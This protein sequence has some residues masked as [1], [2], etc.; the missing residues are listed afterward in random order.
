MDNSQSG[1]PPFAQQTQHIPPFQHV[2]PP[3]FQPPAD[4]VFGQ[5]PAPR[6]GHGRT[7]L[8]VAIGLAVVLVLGFIAGTIAS[9]GSNALSQNAANQLT[10]PDGA[11]ESGQPPA[12]SSP[13][14]APGG[15]SGSDLRKGAVFIQSN[16]ATGNEVAAFSRAS[17]GKLREVGRYRT[18]GNGS[19]SFED[20][21]H[22]IVLGT[23]F[24]ESSPQQNLDGAQL[25]FVTNAGSNSVSV[26][27]VN[28]D[29]LELVTHQPSGGEKP[30]SL[31]VSNGMLYVLNSGELD[32]RFVLRFPDVML[33]NCAHGDQPSV[34]GFRISQE[35]S[36]KPIP[37]SRRTLSGNQKS[38]CA[39]I[40]FTPDGR[41]LI[42]TER[43]ASLAGREPDRGAIVTFDMASNGTPGAKRVQDTA[44]VGPFGFAFTKDGTLLV[45]EQNRAEPGKGTMSSY[46]VLGDGTLKPVSKAVPN[47]QADTC[48]VVPTAD[49]RTA[50]ASNALGEGT[51]SSYSIDDTGALKLLRASA[52]T[53]GDDDDDHLQSGTFDVG[54]SRDSR[55]LYAVNGHFGT[56]QAFEVKEGGSLEFIENHKVFNVV[57][58]EVG[59]QL[60]PFG[61]A[62]Y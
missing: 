8:L 59:G 58:P 10:A 44:G 52:T 33:D 1:Q 49:G 48:W 43:L 50:F 34:T 2:P 11:D 51:I 38:G 61:I 14:A 5:P 42:A 16:A 22:G 47:Q 3:G 27:R 26:F 19:G 4:P 35:G 18:G 55:Y 30:I 24:G 13:A 56:L 41:R 21:A 57:L 32:D 40:S 46:T 28:A 31:A 20:T 23:P 45:T 25:L 7:V 36:L 53:S 62:V 9:G 6:R 15:G 54:L 29:S 17:N 60:P 12:P 39:Q 37:N